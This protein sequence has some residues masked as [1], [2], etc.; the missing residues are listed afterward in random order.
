MQIVQEYQF[1]EEYETAEEYCR[2]GEENEDRSYEPAWNWIMSALVAVQA[3]QEKWEK[4]LTEGRRILE[5]PRLNELARMNIVYLMCLAAE[6][7]RD[8]EK[9]LENAK[10]YIRLAQYFDENPDRLL[11]QVMLSLGDVLLEDSQE[12]I[13]NSLFYSCKSLERY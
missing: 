3:A 8:F 13:Y 12:N 11:E 10:E 6:R 2:R 1:R 4:T 5:L 9:Q 7:I